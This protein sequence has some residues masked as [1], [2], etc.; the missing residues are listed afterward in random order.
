MAALLSVSSP[1][2]MDAFVLRVDALSES[3]A[4]D[5]ALSQDQFRDHGAAL[6]ACGVVPGCRL[7]AYVCAPVVVLAAP[8][9]PAPAE[10][11]P[12]ITASTRWACPTC[13]YN[14]VLSDRVCTVCEYSASPDD[15][16]TQ[17]GPE[18]VAACFGDRAAPRF[19]GRSPAPAPAPAPAPRPVNAHLPACS[20]VWYT[21]VPAT[22]EPR[23]P[24]AAPPLPSPPSDRLHRALS[25]FGREEVRARAI[26]CSQDSVLD[27]MFFLPV[28][29]RWAA[30]YIFVLRSVLP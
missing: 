24:V 17:L 1:L 18:G 27:V 22:T 11:W 9:A 23:G 3:Q 12:R 29:A 19:G 14:N 28:W 5:V 8:P 21:S 25:S 20:W 6:A 4:K 10:T 26:L 7:Y 2:G 30:S 15:I 16:R 13:T